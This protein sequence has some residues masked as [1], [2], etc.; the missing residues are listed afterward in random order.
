MNHKKILLLLLCWAALMP[1]QGQ[2]LLQQACIGDLGYDNGMK[3]IPV[4]HNCFLVGGTTSSTVG[5]GKGNHSN[6]YDIVVGLVSAE[7]KI[8]WQQCIGGTDKEDFG[9]MKRTKDGGVVV[10]GTTNSKDGHASGTHGKMDLIVAKLDALGRF[11]WFKTYGGH[12]NDQGLAIIPLDE[13]GY[14]I[15]G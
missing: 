7:G 13:G 15:G 10:I 11:E 6:N 2:K 5:I 14:L 9:D 4:E 12:G 3:M 1:V 8:I